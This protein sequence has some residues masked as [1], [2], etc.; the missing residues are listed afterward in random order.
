MITKETQ[1]RI[2]A[3]TQRGDYTGWEKQE[4]MQE[5]NLLDLW[6]LS[7]GNGFFLD[8]VTKEI[9]GLF[10]R[11]KVQLNSVRCDTTIEDLDGDYKD[12]TVGMLFDVKIIITE[13]EIKFEG[14]NNCFLIFSR[15]PADWTKFSSD[16]PFETDDNDENY[17]SFYG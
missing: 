5:G 13:G 4:T 1:Y 12:I 17:S 16:E 3:G 9:K 11:K 6:S 14:K 10:S 8:S 7:L 15:E 2:Y